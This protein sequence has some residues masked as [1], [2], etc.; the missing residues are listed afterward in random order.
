M[1]TAIAP[2]SFFASLLYTNVSYTS[3]AAS[4]EPI[5]TVIL[6][7]IFLSEEEFL[8]IRTVSQKIGRGFHDLFFLLYL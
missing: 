8:T 2:L 3:A 7:K 5:I 6:S 1:F 4:I